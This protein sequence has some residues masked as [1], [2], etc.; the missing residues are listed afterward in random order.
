[1]WGA[2]ITGNRTRLL[3][4]WGFINHTT[5][6]VATF[7][8]RSSNAVAT[9]CK[10]VGRCRPR[11]LYFYFLMT[12]A[13][14]GLVNLAP[15]P[16][17]GSRG[18]IFFSERKSQGDKSHRRAKDFIH[19]CIIFWNSCSFGL[20]VHLWEDKNTAVFIFYIYLFV[21]ASSPQSAALRNNF[22]ANVTYLALHFL[23]FFLLLFFAPASHTNSYI[24]SNPN[25]EFHRN[26]SFICIMK[27][28]LPP[29]PSSCRCVSETCAWRSLLELL[30]PPR[31]KN[32]HHRQ[33]EL[34][35]HVHHVA[36]SVGAAYAGDFPRL[37]F[38]AGT[39][40]GSLPAALQN[41]RGVTMVGTVTLFVW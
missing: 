17:A 33:G 36:P 38:S 24:P 10:T 20:T 3:P 2:P 9:Q 40:R 30:L 15:L 11:W 16:P 12:S 31:W 19:E 39:S 8:W 28:K 6:F 29:K 34:T 5:V 25:L 23:F 26:V 13:V 7:C 35:M 27:V 32:P 41:L 37:W 14:L 4:N 18:G 21:P 1:M 22:Y